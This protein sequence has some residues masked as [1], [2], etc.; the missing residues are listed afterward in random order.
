MIMGLCKLKMFLVAKHI[1][2]MMVWRWLI[3]F[4]DDYYHLI[5]ALNEEWDLEYMLHFR[6]MKWKQIRDCGWF[7]YFL[8]DSLCQIGEFE[9]SLN[10]SMDMIR[11]G[12][13]LT[14][15]TLK[16]LVNGHVS[17]LKVYDARK[18]VEKIKTKFPK[19]N[20]NVWWTWW[21][22]ALEILKVVVYSHCAIN[23]SFGVFHSTQIMHMILWITSRTIS[24][25]HVL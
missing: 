21:K 13:V 16:N 7:F 11:E 19:N 8:V 6:F 24:S 1:I 15:T 2:L 22:V 18:L 20:D 23:I 17:I 25:L 12:Y 14:L 9:S 3:P 10:I 4:S 5:V